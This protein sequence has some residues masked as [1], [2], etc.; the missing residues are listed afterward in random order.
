[1]GNSHLDMV[2]NSDD[3]IKNLL[4]LKTNLKTNE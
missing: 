2:L 4:Q 1:M 3:V